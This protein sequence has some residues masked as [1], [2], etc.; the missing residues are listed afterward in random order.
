MEDKKF[1]N[2]CKKVEVY[3]EDETYDIILQSQYL[4]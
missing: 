2:K 1:V 4:K 3:K